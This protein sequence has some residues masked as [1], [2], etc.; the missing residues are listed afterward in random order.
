M[1]DSF[2]SKFLILQMIRV[3]CGMALCVSAIS[4]FA[5]PDAPRSV[6]ATATQS[7]A[8]AL[9]SLD[10]CY[11]NPAGLSLLKDGL[12]IDAGY[13]LLTKTTAS[14]M[15]HS[16]V[17]EGRT[18]W[19]VPNLALA[20]TKK[21][22]GAV[23]LSVFMP[24]GVELFE[25]SKRKGGMPFHAWH[26]L[27]LDSIKMG[28]LRAAGLTVDAGGLELPMITYVRSKRWW[29]QTRLGGSF[30]LDKIFSVAG[31]I[32]W[33]FFMDEQSAGFHHL[34]TVEKT[35]GRGSG[36]SGFFGV[37]IG[38]ADKAA[39]SVLYGTR[40]IARGRER[41]LKYHYSRVAE[42]RLPDSLM[43]G[44]H[45]HTGDGGLVLISYQVDFTGERR[46]GSEKIPSLGREIDYL[47]W[48]TV[49]EN[50]S[51]W[52]ILPVLRAGNS[53]NYKHRHR[54]SVG[55]GLEL[56]MGSFAPL[57]GLSY[58]SQETYPRAQNPLDPDLQRVGL[59][60][61][62][63]IKAGEAITVTSGT[64]YYF[65]VTDRLFFNSIKLNKTA[66]VWGISL[67]AGLL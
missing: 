64:A 27:S 14:A 6:T 3:S 38:P 44:F 52:A 66:W 35:E 48:L 58:S 47:D 32:A 39:L 13:Q 51:T 1:R 41:D 4:L 43:I 46:Y 50:A 26:A 61:G 59:G 62:I 12:H 49:L 17:E 8:P 42:R 67:S 7:S 56:G 53:E 16:N 24:R 55:V 60:A 33:S 9:G 22:K 20:Y 5:Y 15:F 30:A 65:F 19:F 63:K 11:Y 37:M 45:V 36:W 2:K 29:V 21:D 18:S 34:G 28:T 10:G 54:H 40:V 57:V 23:F 31:G 25:Y